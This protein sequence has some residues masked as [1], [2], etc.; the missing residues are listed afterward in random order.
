MDRSRLLTRIIVWMAF[1]M[2]F[3]RAVTRMKQD[4]RPRGLRGGSCLL[5]FGPQAAT[6]A[7]CAFMGP[8]TPRYGSVLPVCSRDQPIPAHRD[9][10]SSKMIFDHHAFVS[11]PLRPSCFTM[12]GGNRQI[13]EN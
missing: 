10:L 2:S 5:Q 7:V 11:R 6:G 1:A 4:R 9:L 3:V 13:T 8:R 12:T